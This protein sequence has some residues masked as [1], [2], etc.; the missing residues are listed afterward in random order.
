M[1]KGLYLEQDG[2]HERREEKTRVREQISACPEV[3]KWNMEKPKDGWR[4]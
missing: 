4:L 3:G 1:E 2:F